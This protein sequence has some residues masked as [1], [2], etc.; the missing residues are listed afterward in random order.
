MLCSGSVDPCYSHA[1]QI[2]NHNLYWKSLSP[3]GGGEPTGDLYYAIIDE[4]GSY[5]DFQVAFTTAASSHFGSG[6]AWVILHEDGSVS[7]RERDTGI[8]RATMM[9][10]AQRGGSGRT[11]HILFLVNG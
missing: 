3:D 6:W 4:F 9:Y 11:G 1:P 8:M 10:G 7:V 5:E 2:Y